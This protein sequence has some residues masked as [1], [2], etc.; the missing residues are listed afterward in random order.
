MAKRL[1]ELTAAIEAAKL[2]QTANER[3][4]AIQ[5]RAAERTKAI[6]SAI[7]S[8]RGGETDPDDDTEPLT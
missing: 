6:Q 2:L 8:R 5:A 7:S 4:V 1:P 3:V